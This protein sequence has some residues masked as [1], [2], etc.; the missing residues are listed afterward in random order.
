MLRASILR[1]GGAWEEYL[2]LCEFAHNNNA[3]KA[4]I[5]MPPFEALYGRPCRSPACWA[6]PED[7]AVIGPEVV[8][9]H[10]E[11]IRQVRLRLQAAQDRQ[12]KYADRYLEGL[13]YDVDDLVYL[14]VSPWKGHQRFGIKGK[15]APRYIGPFRVI[16]RV[17]TVAYRL[18]L[19]QS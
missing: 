2:P 8:V 14:K 10:T 9:D 12:K 1:F 15:L 5:G 6:A 11:K 18:E 3:I 17:G 4:S 7:V 19:P 16:A 13:S